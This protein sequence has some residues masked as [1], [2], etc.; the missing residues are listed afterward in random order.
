MRTGSRSYF[1]AGEHQYI[2]RIRHFLETGATAVTDEARDL[3][4]QYATRCS[5]VNETL[6]QC[7]KYLDQG[8]RTEAIHLAET[9]PPALEVAA[10]L[11]FPEAATWRTFCAQRDLATPEPLDGETV[12]RLNQAYVEEESLAAVLSEYRAVARRGSLA[13]KISMLRRIARLDPDNANW[14]K[15][16]EQFE[17]ARHRELSQEAPLV[18]RGAVIA[19]VQALVAELESPE[20]I[21]PPDRALLE[22]ARRRVADLRAQLARE[23]SRVIAERVWSAYGA[24]DFERTTAALEQW[25]SLLAE[26]GFT[27]PADVAGQVAEAEE[28]RRSQHDRRD[29]NRDFRRRLA[30]LDAALDRKAP[31]AEVERIYYAARRH[32]R[33]IPRALSVRA[34]RFLENAR[35]AETRRFRMRVAA[36][37]VAIAAVAAPIFLFVHHRLKVQR[38]TRWEREIDQAIEGRDYD[39]ARRLIADLRKRKPDVFSDPAIQERAERIAREGKEH[40]TRRRTFANAMRQLQEIR[41]AK[42]PTGRPYAGL[43]RIAE[44]AATTSPERLLLE[45]WRIARRSHEAAAQ[46]RLDGRFSA[47]VSGLMKTLEALQRSDPEKDPAAYRALVVK[48]REELGGAGFIP[49]V[50]RSMR[51][52]LPAMSKRLKMHDDALR[53][54]VDRLAKQASALKTIEGALPDLGKCE[55]LISAFLRDY[56]HNTAAPRLRRLLGDC[57]Y[58]RDLERGRLWQPAPDQAMTARARKFLDSKESRDSMW[59]EPLKRLLLEAEAAARAPA[60]VKSLDEMRENWRLYT[61]YSVVVVNSETGERTRYYFRKKPGRQKVWDAGRERMD[62]RLA[63][64]GKKHAERLKI[65]PPARFKPALKPKLEDNL[66]P[67]CR[68]VRGLLA[69]ARKAKP[70]ELEGYLL[71]QAEALRVNAAIDPVIRVSLLRAL[72]RQVKR[73]TFDNV[74]LVDRA[75][76]QVD[77]LNTNYYWMDPSPD[78]ETLAVKQKFL[79]IL[80]A[81]NEVLVMALNETARERVE[82]ACLSRQAKCIGVV[83]GAGDGVRMDLRGTRPPEVWIVGG[84][85]LGRPTVRIVATRGMGATLAPLRSAENLLY[86]GQPLFAPMDGKQTEDW[87]EAIIKGIPRD[88]LNTIESMPWPLCWPVNCRDF[89]AVDGGE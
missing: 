72:L 42:F 54:A 8:M 88:R 12:S 18:I 31:A 62:H 47:V 32:E 39:K 68:F 57:G 11:D 6:R 27:P 28:W 82:N 52:R 22:N 51:D 46:S 23:R 25:S 34:E 59:R 56:P 89:E 50:S 9:P 63:V 58:G 4:D 74:G 14:L 78:Q 49:G 36:I 55:R 83:A 76:K 53:K 71:R 7:R 44:A 41:D 60:A 43:E 70:W 26:G 38:R 15:D 19:P 45:E 77:D 5:E 40:G 24:L 67:H 69:G 37:V 86:Q 10:A 30:E 79:R 20:W 48:A 87:L 21:V 17:R 85:S 80:G 64:F 35:L 33:E 84:D 2:A 73:L 66:A 13:Q 3:A 61:V 29:S 1:V 65:I 81:M 75:L 16:L